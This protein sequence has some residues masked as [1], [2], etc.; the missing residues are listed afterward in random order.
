MNVVVI[1]YETKDSRGASFEYY[2]KDF[3]VFSLSAAYR[4]AQGEIITD[5]L[6][7]PQ[8]INDYLVALAKARTPIVAFNLPFELGVSEACFPGLRLNWYADALRLCQLRDGGGNEFEAPILTIEQEIAVELGELDDTAVKKQWNKRIGLSL[9]ACSRRFLSEEHHNHKAEAH[10][11]LEENLGITKNHGGNLDKL[12]LDILRR[13]NDGDTINTLYLY[14]ESLQY[15]KEI[16][17]DWERDNLLYLDRS[18]SMARAYRAGIEIDRDALYKYL[19]KLRNQL[20][21]IESQFYSKFEEP[22]KDLVALRKEQFI[23]KMFTD[24]KVK[25]EA[26]RYKR[27]EAILEGKWEDKYNNFTLGSNQQLTMLFMDILG[28][29]DVSFYTKKGSPSFKATHLHQWGEGGEML[30]KRRQ[31]M[32]VYQQC[33]NTYLLSEFNGRAH[34]SIKVSGTRTNRVAGGRI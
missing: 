13:Y 25:T 8:E 32:L 29:T 30:A 26:T 10:T 27:W 31:V 15:F 28:Q 16:R 5:F 3:E 17:F 21:D 14:E 24:P 22:L 9:E 19:I 18:Q 4:D 33:I 12:P 11:W 34:P 6:T 7:E 20:M 2:R 23:H 1:D